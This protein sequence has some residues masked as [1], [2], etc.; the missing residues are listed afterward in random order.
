MLNLNLE[1]LRM[2]LQVS[3]DIEQRINMRLHIQSGV[4]VDDVLRDALDALDFQEQEIA[5]IREGL[6]DVEAG[7]LVPLREY[8]REFRDRRNV[9]QDV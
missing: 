3:A 1:E 8:E 5:A 6:D 4:T 7:R 9:S 2:T